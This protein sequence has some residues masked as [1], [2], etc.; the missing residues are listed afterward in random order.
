MNDGEDDNGSDGDDC[1]TS[2]CERADGE[3]DAAS[4]VDSKAKKSCCLERNGIVV[5]FPPYF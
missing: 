4:G 2:G 5:I 1:D 3:N